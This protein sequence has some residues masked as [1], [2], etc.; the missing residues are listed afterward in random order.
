MDASDG[1]SPSTVG[2]GLL[3]SDCPSLR[4]FIITNYVKKLNNNHVKKAKTKNKQ[5]II[6]G[7]GMIRYVFL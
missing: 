1:L 5:Q 4:L 7:N 6:L 3:Y 2:A